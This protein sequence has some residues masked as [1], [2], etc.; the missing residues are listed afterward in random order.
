MKQKN[1]I[2]R[3][4]LINKKFQLS[5]ALK[6]T[7]IQIPCILVTGISISW[8]YLIFMDNRL[9]TDSNPGIFLH[10][11]FLIILLSCGVIFFSIRFTH[12]I[13]G[14][15]QKTGVVLRQIANGNLPEKKIKFRKKDSFK[16]LSNDLNHMID[17]IR[18]D[19]L[20][21]KNTTEKLESLKNDI[22]NNYADQNQCLGKIE[23]IL[24][25][26][27]TKNKGLKN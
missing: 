22:I 13:A 4:Y 1:T 16:N 25:I 3:K 10:M 11:F 12:S 8:F 6:I 19:R 27:N 5:N 9:Y 24:N 15:V 20:V 18:K 26:I 21:Y 14:P 17:S 2:K 23:D 7:A